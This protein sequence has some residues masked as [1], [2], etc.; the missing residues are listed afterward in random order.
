MQHKFLDHFIFM[1]MAGC[2]LLLSFVFSTIIYFVIQSQERDES[3]QLAN[4]LMK[5]VSSTATAALFSNNKDV[6]NDVINGLLSNDS[7]HSVKLI[8]YADD[9]NP[10]FVWSAANANSDNSLNEMSLELKSPFDE[11]ATLGKIVVTPSENWVNQNSQERALELIIGLIIVIFSTCFLTAQ[12]IRH[13]ISTP[14]TSAVKQL[15]LIKPGDNTQVE[16]P[17]HLQQNEIGS[18]ISVFNSLLNKVRKAILVE[19]QLRERME[20]VKTNLEVAKN[21]AI[22]ATETKSNFLAVMSHEIRTPMNAIIGFL[23]LAIED[24]SLTE[25]T[26]KHLTISLSS[27]HFLLQLINDV[28]DLSKIESGKL[29][30]DLQSFD[31]VNILTKVQELMA[32]KA[33]EKNLKLTLSIPDKMAKSY[34]GDPFRLQQIL[35]NLISNAIK[36]THEGAIVIKLEEHADNQFVFSVIDTG[37]GIPENKIEQILEPFT[38]VDASISRHYGGTGLGTSIAS[39]LVKL[40]GGKLSI[41]SKLGEGSCFY[42]TIKLPPSNTAT[43]L[44]QHSHEAESNKVDPMLILVAD[45]VK[46]NI[47]LMRIHLEKAGHTVHEALNGKQALEKAKEHCYNLL[48]IDLQMPVM[49][50]YTACEKIRKLNEHYQKVHIIIATAGSDNADISRLKKLNITSLISKPISYK[51]LFSIIYQ[52][53]NHSTSSFASTVENTSQAI[54]DSEAAL[55]NWIE[56]NALKSA[57]ISFKKSNQNLAE[58]LIISAKKNDFN[59]LEKE[60]H[61][62]KGV[63]GNLCLFQLAEQAKI[64]ENKIHIQQTKNIKLTVYE[65]NTVLQKTLSIINNYNISSKDTEHKAAKHTPNQTNLVSILRNIKHACYQNDPDIAERAIKQLEPHQL[66]VSMAMNDSLQQ[67]DFETLENLTDELLSTIEQEAFNQ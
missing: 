31:L 22:K 25:S 16:V 14:L 49:D 54:F 24:K 67:F 18:L 55:N 11:N 19:R 26:Q 41:K 20:V 1:I 15:T 6:G 48:L 61:R 43:A 64:L 40:M 36:F 27:A 53:H 12:L 45:D 3:Y 23:E 58:T 9:L 59:T 5:T 63:A 7:I 33:K 44:V 47:V 65:F 52:Q 13:L 37:V 21:Q 30:L 60:A 29:E 62:I 17:A 39:D 57:L 34:C 50:G 35:F 10:S 46:E 56:P 51:Q 28:L 8:G 38:Q 32:I 2:A 4:Y 42:F 66:S